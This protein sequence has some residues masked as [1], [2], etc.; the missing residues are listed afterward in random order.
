MKNK[1]LQFRTALNLT[2]EEAARRCGI[3]TITLG[4]IERGR[5]TSQ[6]TARV[7]AAALQQKPEVVFPD[8]K[9][10]RRW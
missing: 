4:T 5:P 7:I 10:L 1:V 6:P 8:F 9:N 2:Q 3:P